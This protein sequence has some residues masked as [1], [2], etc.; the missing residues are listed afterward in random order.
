MVVIDVYT[1][2]VR[3]RA[4]KLKAEA[5]N[6]KRDKTKSND[7]M[8]CGDA[9]TVVELQTCDIPVPHNAPVTQ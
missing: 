5:R 4:T 7:G 3:K 8:C 6:L 9:P 2:K 1:I